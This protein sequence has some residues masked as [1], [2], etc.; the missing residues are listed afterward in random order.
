MNH[1]RNGMVLNESFKQ[2]NAP[3]EFFHGQ[4][5]AYIVARTKTVHASNST[6]SLLLR[7]SPVFVEKP[8]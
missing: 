2:V 6:T 1:S 8:E 5:F 7:K 3:E 4:Q